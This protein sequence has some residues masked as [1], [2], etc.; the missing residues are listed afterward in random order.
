MRKMKVKMMVMRILTRF[1]SCIILFYGLSM[2]IG[3]I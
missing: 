3:T 1:I 2:M